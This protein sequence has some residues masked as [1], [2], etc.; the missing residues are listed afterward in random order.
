M[1][2]GT[3]KPYFFHLDVYSASRTPA[4]GHLIADQRD[5]RIFERRV[6]PSESKPH[7]F[8]LPTQNAQ[9]D[10]TTSETR[11]Q[12]EPETARAPIQNSSV[13]AN[14]ANTPCFA[15]PRHDQRPRPC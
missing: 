15:E 3:G 6:S 9:L 10:I 4:A 14:N 11:N 12:T 8:R 1:Q 5:A 13:A 7:F 2:I